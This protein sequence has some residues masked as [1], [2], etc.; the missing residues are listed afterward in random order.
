MP[1]NDIIL[2]KSIRYFHSETLV[3]SSKFGLPSQVSSPHRFHYCILSLNTV[4]EILYRVCRIHSLTIFQ[5]QVGLAFSLGSIR[6][7]VLLDY[8]NRLKD[9]RGKAVVKK[10]HARLIGTINDQISVRNQERFASGKLTYPYFL[11]KW[12]PNS[13]QT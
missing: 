8:G 4:S 3:F 13:I 2:R 9:D 11:P 1:N 6:Y 7:D 10:Y 12:M 5:E